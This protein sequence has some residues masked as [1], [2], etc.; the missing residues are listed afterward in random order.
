MTGRGT[1]S[2]VV[3]NLCDAEAGGVNLR[4]DGVIFEVAVPQ[5]SAVAEAPPNISGVVHTM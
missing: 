3:T 1:A 2:R 5:G 4:R